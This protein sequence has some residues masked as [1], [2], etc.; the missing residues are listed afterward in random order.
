MIK[1]KKGFT[2]IE[3]IVTI[4]IMVLLGI[5]IVVNMSGILSSQND[6]DYEAFKNKLQDA[7]CIY[8]ETNWEEEKRKECKNRNDCTIK[9]VELIKE[10][11]IED[12][13][14]NPSN[15]EYASKY[16]I[17]VKWM[18]NVKTCELIS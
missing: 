1:D 13:I 7:A 15:G 10:G 16:T 8:V 5:V 4:G 18:N 3:L 17:S 14:K 12:T 6:S 2:L 11:L 9:V